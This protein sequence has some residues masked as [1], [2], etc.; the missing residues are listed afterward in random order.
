MEIIQ[1][2]YALADALAENDIP[3][4]I[5]GGLA[6][7]IH[8]RPRMTVDIDLVV[9]SEFIEK[10]AEIAQELGFDDVAGWVKL[11]KSELGIDRLYR[12]NKLQGKDFLT[13]DILEADSAENSIFAD[14]Q[15]FQLERRQLSVLSKQ[16]LIRM[17]KGTGRTQDQLDVEMLTDE[18]E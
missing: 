13:L 10:A 3:Y 5:C 12:I 15:M 8:G 1:E 11:S 14:R 16:A 9:P 6:V 2:L 18:I 4:A 17:K 7:A